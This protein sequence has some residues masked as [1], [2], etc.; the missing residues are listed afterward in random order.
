MKKRLRLKDSVKM[1][2]IIF[3]IIFGT[4]ALI[5]ISTYNNTDKLNKCLQTH[6]LDYCN[7]EVR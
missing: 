7:R 4:L 5:Y 6:D 3:L 1:Y 2:I